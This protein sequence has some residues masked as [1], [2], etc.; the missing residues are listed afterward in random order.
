MKLLNRAYS[1][2]AE[3][4]HFEIPGRIGRWNVGFL[5]VQTR[6][7]VR[8]DG[9]IVPGTNLLASRISYDVT[10]KLRFGSIVTNGSPDGVTRNTLAGFDGVYRTSEFLGNKN[11]FVGAWT[12]FATG[13]LRDGNRTGYG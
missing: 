9:A 1:A 13:D 4:A 6:S 12:A 11:F 10:P 3:K 8:R 2:P 5:D 7:T